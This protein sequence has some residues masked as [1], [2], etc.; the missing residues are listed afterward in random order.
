MA[1]ATEKSPNSAAAQEGLCY[2]LYNARRVP[3]ALA[4]CERALVIEPARTDAR[5]NRANAL[6]A[7]S[8]WCMAMFLYRMRLKAEAQPLI[9]KGVDAGFEAFIGGYRSAHVLALALCEGPALFGVVICFLS[10]QFGV[11]GENPLLWANSLTLLG[12]LAAVS[13]LWP[14]AARFRRLVPALVQQAELGR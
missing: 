10:V 14:T 11:I 8:C 7:L 5:I 13:V 12:M 9:E 2:A 4:A 1:S 3:E 6:L